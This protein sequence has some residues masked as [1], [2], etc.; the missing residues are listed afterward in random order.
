MTTLTRTSTP[1]PPVVVP[2]RK[3]DTAGGDRAVATVSHTVLIIW[4]IIV[5]LPL[6]W[7]LLSSF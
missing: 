4:S 6:L 3:G 1:G 7:T 5:I 2:G